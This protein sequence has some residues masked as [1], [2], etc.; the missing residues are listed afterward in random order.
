MSRKDCVD[1]I[2][3][4]KVHLPIHG[5][6]HS[7]RAK[8]TVVSKSGKEATVTMLAPGD[9]IGEESLS[10]GAEGHNNLCWCREGGSNPNRYSNH[11]SY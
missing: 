3:Q 10:G 8:L 4:A 7:G 5:F 6:P 9:F 11:V 2:A 1:Y